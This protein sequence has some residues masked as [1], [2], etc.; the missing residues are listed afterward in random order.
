MCASTLPR[1]ESKVSKKTMV[2]ELD[3]FFQDIE[4]SPATEANFHRIQEKREE[5]LD[6]LRLKHLNKLFEPGY[7][8]TPFQYECMGD[9][10]HYLYLFDKALYQ[11]DTTPPRYS[12]KNFWDSQ[13]NITKTSMKDFSEKYNDK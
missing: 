8:K 6:W 2:E 5:F 11:L 4:G 7:Q 10:F 13:D 3:K 1:V 12:Y 9:I